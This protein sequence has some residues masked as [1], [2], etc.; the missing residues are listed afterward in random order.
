MIIGNKRFEDSGKTYIM[1]ILNTTPDSFS[2]GGYYYQYD[3]AIRHIEQ[4]IEDGADIID[5][6]GQS[7]R[8]GCEPVGADEELRRIIPV[9]EHIKKNYDVPISV[10]TYD[11]RVAKEAIE[12][13]ADMINDVWGLDYDNGAPD[14][15]DNMAAVIS[16]NEVSVC[17][18]HNS[19][20]M[21]EVDINITG[22]KELVIS[23]ELDK[24]VEK[25]RKSVHIALSSGIPRNRIMID[26]GV[27]FAKDY[28]MNMASIAN[29]VQLKKIGFPILL[30]ASEKSV[31]GETLDLPVRDR[32]EGTLTTTVFAVLSGCSYVRVH[33]VKSNRRAIMMA[34]ELLNYRI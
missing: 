7:T 20:N 6:G 19:K 25:L 11:S 8:P 16:K 32:L 13:G 5:I 27:G 3:D 21:C 31:I 29:L 10:D 24:I 14:S 18:M 12:A 28:N 17:I 22:N 26:P 34:E 15:Y 1:A 2:D 30:G 9:I 33:D 23:R 4:V